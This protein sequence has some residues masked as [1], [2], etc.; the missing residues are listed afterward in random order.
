MN[1]SAEQRLVLFAVLSGLLTWFILASPSLL[2]HAL[3]WL[4]NHLS[5]R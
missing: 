2:V 1:L 3:F 4:F 5:K